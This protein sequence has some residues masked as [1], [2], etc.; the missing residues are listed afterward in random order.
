MVGSIACYVSGC[1]NPAIGQCAGY[2]GRCGQFHCRTHS[3]GKL[4]TE[5]GEREL[6]DSQQSELER[7]IDRIREEYGQAIGGITEK[8]K[9]INV[10]I[11]AIPIAACL[12]LS[13][14]AASLVALLVLVVLCISYWIFRTN[15]AEKSMTEAERTKPEFRRYYEMFR[16]MKA[17]DKTNAPWDDAELVD[18]LTLMV[19]LAERRLKARG[20]WR[21]DISINHHQMA[22]EIAKKLTKQFEAEDAQVGPSAP[23]TARR[24]LGLGGRILLGAAEGLVMGTGEAARGMMKDVTKPAQSPEE[25]A[26][27]DLKDEVR[28]LR[29]ER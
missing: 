21:S 1:G 13:G 4:C 2:G 5:C 19:G 20:E 28:K 14:T 10:A 15:K 8:P 11:V 6:L 23:S 27:S 22:G 12:L 9:A 24:A 26:I 18:M 16:E 29:Y 25:L 17:K 3:V 7:E